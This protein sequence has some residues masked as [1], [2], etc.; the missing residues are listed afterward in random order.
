MGAGGEGPDTVR[1]ALRR[2]EEAGEEKKPRRPARKQKDQE[3]PA[4]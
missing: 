2:L 4:G 1:A 3:P